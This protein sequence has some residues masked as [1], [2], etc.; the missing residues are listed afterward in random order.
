MLKILGSNFYISRPK[1]HQLFRTNDTVNL[2]VI[3]KIGEDVNESLECTAI[4][5]YDPAIRPAPT[6]IANTN[7]EYIPMLAT[8]TAPTM[9]YSPLVRRCVNE[10]GGV[11]GKMI[12]KKMQPLVE[13]FNSILYQQSMMESDKTV[14]RTLCPLPLAPQEIMQ[15]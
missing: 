5:T 2:S 7:N 14:R 3:P 4:E 10:I 12:E 13:G 15:Q 9:S 11:I 6:S 1:A 8:N